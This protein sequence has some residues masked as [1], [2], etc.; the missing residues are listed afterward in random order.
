MSYDHRLADKIR[1]ALSNHSGVSEQGK[2]GGITFMLDGNVCVRAHSDGGMMVRCEP[3][4]TERFLKE[5]GVRRFEMKGRSL[6]KGWLLVD[7][8]QLGGEQSLERWVSVAIDACS[9]LS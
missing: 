5:G 3:S 9:R 8:G 1:K 6:M 4:M 7:S 2:M